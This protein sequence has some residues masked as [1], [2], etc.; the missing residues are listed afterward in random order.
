MATDQEYQISIILLI[1]WRTY[2]HNKRN[3]QIFSNFDRV[4]RFKDIVYQ[5]HIRDTDGIH[6]SVRFIEIQ[7]KFTKDPKKSEFVKY[8]I[9][10]LK[11]GSYFKT[12]CFLKRNILNQTISSFRDS[13][14]GEM[15]IIK[16]N[17]V[18]PIMYSYFKEVRMNKIWR[19]DELVPGKQF[20]HTKA[21]QIKDEQCKKLLSP[22]IKN[23][24][25]EYNAL[26]KDLCDIICG[27]RILKF[28]GANKKFGKYEDALLHDVFRVD[29]SERTKYR[30][31]H[32]FLTSKKQFCKDLRNE[33]MFRNEGKKLMKHPIELVPHKPYSFLTENIHTLAMSLSRIIKWGY[34]SWGYSTNYDMLV[35]NEVIKTNQKE[36]RQC[37]IH[38]SPEKSNKPKLTPNATEFRR[39]FIRELYNETVN[40]EALHSVRIEIVKQTGR[41]AEK[42][43]PLPYWYTDEDLD[44]F[45]NQFRIIVNYPDV[46]ELNELLFSEVE[47]MYPNMDLLTMLQ[48]KITQQMTQ[49]EC[50]SHTVNDLDNL[51]V[52]KIKDKI[53]NATQAKTM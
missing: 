46:P 50:I 12:F 42:Q 52:T 38:N 33:I 18:T 36:L 17:D 11:V 10:Q 48:K 9:K 31:N 20:C 6:S 39:L 14:L 34:L 32:D 7:N 41:I 45:I 51:I 23:A 19:L 13:V 40:Y 4:K 47:Q 1:L 5:A 27:E 21:L 37:F 49:I 44:D 15:F 8:G 16:N 53:G 3:L 35:K 26:I 28:T 29:Q 2:Q 43:H 24:H 25:Q 22:F 30:F